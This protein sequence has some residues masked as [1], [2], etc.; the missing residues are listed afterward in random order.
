MPDVSIEISARDNYSNTITS[1]RNSNQ[2]FNKDLEG[3]QNAISDLL[4]KQDAL[5]QMKKKMQTDLD[6]ASASLK[7]A[8]KAFADN[9]DEI[10]RTNLETAHENYNKISDD[11]KNLNSEAKDTQKSIR[12][13]SEEQSKQENKAGT[14]GG[15]GSTENSLVSRLAGAGLTKMFG[16]SISGAAQAYITSAFSDETGT[17]V[18]SILGG[19]TSGAALGTAVLPGLG[20]A[21]GAT[22]GAASGAITAATKTFE[23]KENAFKSTVQDQYSSI[24]ST[25]GSDLTSGISS[26]SEREGDLRAF[27]NLLGSADDAEKFQKWI[28]EAGRTPPFSYDTVSQLSKEMIGLGDSAADVKRKISDL[29]EVAAAEN[30]STSTTESVNAVLNQTL[31]SGEV[32]SRVLKTLDRYGLHAEEAI[33]KAFGIDPSKV[34][35][36]ISKLDPTSVVN[37]IYNYMGEKFGGSSKTLTNTYAGQLG[38]SQSYD[39]DQ[40]SAMGKGYENAR[41]PALEEHNKMMSGSIGK[42][43]EEANSM[44]GKFKA[45]LDNTQEELIDNAKASIV[46]GK[47]TGDYADTSTDEGRKQN[48]Q[49]KKQLQTLADDY[50]NQRAKAAAGDEEAA[51]KQAEDVEEAYII[52]QNAYKLSKGYQLEEQGNLDL[53]TRIQDDNALN[54]AYYD[55]G[56]KFGQKLSTGTIKAIQ[57][58]Y[59]KGLQPSSTLPW[60]SSSTDSSGKTSPTGLT[61]HAKSIGMGGMA[62][63]GNATGL[64]RVPY[65]NYPTLLHEGETVSTA[66]E[67]RSQK[68]G[69]VQVIIQGPVTVRKESDI[70]EIASQ[71]YEKLKRADAVTP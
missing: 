42:D 61:G 18:S 64:F 27:T 48:E 15:L 28:I 54:T 24:K 1:M 32:S 23:N 16:D 52:A 14:G 71:L 46:S 69:G 31:A 49:I 51:K 5:S 9:N 8:K 47:V 63:S 59:A 6:E 30:W 20:T 60:M 25:E 11:L 57:E 38:I 13:L 62:G 50:K 3:T 12:S 22:V 21:I 2:S 36:K 70:D 65:N 17:A 29:G 68:G 66:V 34:S 45:D 19:V 7:Q 67:A 4:K 37:A 56:Y 55:T 26:A 43:I 58:N 33:G 53:I 35:D 39:E 40:Q 41:T 10:N 44:L